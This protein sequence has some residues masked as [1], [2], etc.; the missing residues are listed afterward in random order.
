MSFNQNTNI[1]VY[2][3]GKP[4]HTHGEPSIPLPMKT[5]IKD[6]DFKTMNNDT[7]VRLLEKPIQTIIPTNTQRRV[8]YVKYWLSDNDIPALVDQWKSA[9]I[10]HILLTFITQ[11][12]AKKPLSDAIRKL[13]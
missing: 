1:S 10:T 7:T 3:I 11:P 6:L 4:L 2:L 9:N 12:D 13:V 5:R 8:I